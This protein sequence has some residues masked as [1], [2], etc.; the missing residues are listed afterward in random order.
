[1][2][3]LSE[4]EEINCGADSR[5]ASIKIMFYY[6]CLVAQLISREDATVTCSETSFTYKRL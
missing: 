2:L 6:P 3:E 4:E 1:M 5:N